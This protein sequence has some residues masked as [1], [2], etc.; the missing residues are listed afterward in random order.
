MEAISGRKT[1]QEIAAVHAIH[2]IRVSQWK[3]QLLD[4]ASELF[5]RGKKNKDTGESQTKAAEV[6]QQIGRLQMELEWLKKSLSCSDA[7]KLRKLVDHDHP[8]L[9]VSCQCALLGL[10]RSTLYY[11]PMP[12]RESTLRIMARID[13]LYLEDACIGSRRMVDYLAR[14]DIPISRDRVR[15]LMRRM[16]LR[17]RRRLDRGDRATT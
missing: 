8:E 9:S 4:G 1:I 12:E 14:E 10:S 7:S 6:F 3:R 5:T 2:P 16:G 15:N 11:R 13:A 17:V